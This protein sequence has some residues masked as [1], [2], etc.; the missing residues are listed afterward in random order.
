MH[1]NI[2]ELFGDY[3]GSYSVNKLQLVKNSTLRVATG[4]LIMPAIDHLHMGADIMTVRE[5]L[6]MLCSQALATF[7][8]EGHSLL[9]VVTAD[10]GATGQKANPPTTLHSRTRIE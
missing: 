1:E 8:Q 4:C 5:H 7:L 2:Y 10:S 3:S 9:P 6:D